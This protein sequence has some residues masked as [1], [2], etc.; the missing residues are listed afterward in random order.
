MMSRLFDPERKSRLDDPERAQWQKPDDVVAALGLETGSIVCD[1]GAGT[2]YFAFRIAKKVGPSGKV[3]AL[4]LQEKMLSSLK[5]RIA[6]DG[7]TNV[8]PVLTGL[9]DS[10]LPDGSVDLVFVANVAHEFEDLEAG[11]R[12]WSR[13]LRP[14][15]KLVI[16]DWKPE[17]TPK[18][19][20]LDH[21]LSPER[22]ER[23]SASAGFSHGGSLDAL[24]YHYFLTFNKR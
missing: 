20:P 13:I 12:E 17:E 14:E 11:M 22:I 4:D 3:Y 24:P 9:V 21:R 10:G 8:I 16:V 18:G 23:T 1:I 6:T 7:V 2:G 15:G 5:E 19:P